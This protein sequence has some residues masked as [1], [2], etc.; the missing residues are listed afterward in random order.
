ML[1]DE[2]FAVH[3]WLGEISCGVTGVQISL[4]LSSAPP[5]LMCSTQLPHKGSHAMAGCLSS[6]PVML[7]G[8]MLRAIRAATCDE[9]LSV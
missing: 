6:A 4:R 3:D 2:L 8:F 5:Q 9:R 1:M 7:Q